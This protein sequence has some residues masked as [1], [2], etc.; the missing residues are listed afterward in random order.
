MIR[1]TDEESGGVAL[2]FAERLSWFVDAWWMYVRWV[3]EPLR[4]GWIPLQ[5]S[6]LHRSKSYQIMIFFMIHSLVHLSRP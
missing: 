2:F 4:S 3:R 5:I 6:H 1:S